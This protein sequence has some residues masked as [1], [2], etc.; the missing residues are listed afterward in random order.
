MSRPLLTLNW[1]RVVRQNTL[2]HRHAQPLPL[3][4]KLLAQSVNFN[5]TAASLHDFAGF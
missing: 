2:R 4:A 1:L 3:G 5:A